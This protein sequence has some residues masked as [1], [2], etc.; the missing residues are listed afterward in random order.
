[1]ELTLLC[2]AELAPEL[3]VPDETNIN[4]S[5]FMT[6]PCEVTLK[7][8]LFSK[9][10]CKNACEHVWEAPPPLAPVSWSTYEPDTPSDEDVLSKCRVQHKG[11][12]IDIS[13]LAPL[14][15]VLPENNGDKYSWQIGFCRKVAFSSILPLE[16]CTGENGAGYV[17]QYSGVTCQAEFN[18]NL[19][20][21]H[22]DDGR[23]YGLDIVADGTPGRHHDKQV[24][25][26]VT[27]DATAKGA[28]IDY[29]W[30]RVESVV[31][32]KTR[33]Y[34]IHLKSHCACH[35]ACSHK[36]LSAW[37]EESQAFQTNEAVELGLFKDCSVKGLDLSGLNDDV[38][39]YPQQWIGHE[40]AQANHEQYYW[41]IGFCHQVVTPP[42]LGFD[43]CTFRGGWGYL[44]QFSRGRCQ[45]NFKHDPVIAALPKSAGDGVSFTYHDDHDQSQRREA[46][47]AVRCDPDQHVL[48]WDAEAMPTMEV[49]VEDLPG[50]GL[51]YTMAFKHRCVCSTLQ[52]PCE[53]AIVKTVGFDLPKPSVARDLAQCSMSGRNLAGL[54]VF[55]NVLVEHDQNG[56]QTG[57][58]ALWVIGFCNSVTE[59]DTHCGGAGFAQ[60]FSQ[61]Q[62]VNNF[63]ASEG[64]TV[65]EQDG[66]VVR[67]VTYD[68]QTNADTSHKLHVSI[69]CRED[70]KPFKVQPKGDFKYTAVQSEG[71]LS[72]YY[73][74]FYSKC[75]CKDGCSDVSHHVPPTAHSP[76]RP[77]SPPPAP[78]P[79]RPSGQPVSSLG[80]VDQI[81]GPDVTPGNPE[82][83][84]A[85]DI[86]LSGILYPWSQDLQGVPSA[87]QFSTWNIGFC[88]QVDHS[89]TRFNTPCTGQPGYV[90]YWQ[91][92]KCMLSTDSN[93]QLDRCNS[94]QF[95]GK[96]YPQG[97]RLTST[98]M[99]G[100]TTTTARIIVLCDPSVKSANPA[101]YSDVVQSDNTFT[102]VF[103]SSCACSGRDAEACPTHRGPPVAVLPPPSPVDDNDASTAITPYG[104]CYASNDQ[105][106]DISSLTYRVYTHV[107]A[108]WS[109]ADYS[110]GMGWCYPRNFADV[111]FNPCTRYG[112]GFFEIWGSDVD[113][114]SAQ[115]C[116]AHFDKIEAI[117]QQTNPAI[118]RGNGL[119]IKLSSTSSLS[120]A[121]INLVCDQKADGTEPCCD[122]DKHKV[123]RKSLGGV[124]NYQIT[125]ESKCACPGGCPKVDVADGADPADEVV[126]PYY[127]YMYQDCRLKTPEGNIDLSS[128]DPWPI[129][130]PDRHTF[131]QGGDEVPYQWTVGLC[132]RVAQ[133]PL[134]TKS[135]DVCAQSKGAGWL[136]QY[137]EDPPKCYADFNDDFWSMRP[138]VQNSKVLGVNVTVKTSAGQTGAGSKHHT[139]YAEILMMCNMDVAGEPVAKMDDV[140]VD[141][142][143]GPTGAI[144]YIYKMTFEHKCACPGANCYHHA[145]PHLRTESQAVEHITECGLEKHN[146]YLGTLPTPYEFKQTQNY[147][148]EG[149]I[150]SGLSMFGW[151]VG[152]CSHVVKTHEGIDPC[153]IQAEKD[154]RQPGYIQQYSTNMQGEDVTGCAV[155]FNEV[156]A[157]A[158]YDEAT[159]TVNVW[160]MFR[161]SH[162]P[163]HHHKI[164]NMKLICAPSMEPGHVAEES[165]PISV[166]PTPLKLLPPDLKVCACVRHCCFLWTASF[167]CLLQ[168]SFLSKFP[169]NGRDIPD[170]MDILEYQMNFQYGIVYLLFSPVSCGLIHP[171]S[172]P[173]RLQ[174][175]VCLQ[176]WL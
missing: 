78:R 109:A 87:R 160:Y 63:H 99:V 120:A 72:A 42:A 144:E 90:Q 56:A 64:F 93:L 164:V 166:L 130:M 95:K 24:K 172:M 23:D 176:G 67:F 153:I 100:G 82:E 10:A 20:V 146:V 9:C 38:K 27:C 122:D 60:R 66:G 2:S 174:F 89:Q 77:S 81:C 39:L 143:L 58:E 111:G 69:Y 139:K 101:Q 19:K 92:E 52:T 105:T 32:G 5:Q 131:E 28:E 48:K 46:V 80:E 170:D 71:S 65:D 47:I 151:A 16:P 41:S 102:I 126:F 73:I 96:S 118:G 75:A 163:P 113:G 54:D 133:D 34:T 114:R 154:Q 98:S 107:P 51:K 142:F 76:P 15:V 124:L 149:H 59:K 145:A 74:D 138:L 141:Q 167:F 21:T 29:L 18:S 171:L 108:S 155:D 49:K 61:G 8:S 161:N 88:S 168:R 152:W 121:T 22:F 157:P 123:I 97:V 26:R 156:L 6:N 53:H 36:S 33:Y 94:A 106:R 14:D 162:V 117:L 79:P 12:W 136:H 43:P 116:E 175:Q 135:G 44:Q 104:A 110:L 103:G 129:V 147:T 55:E 13:S 30:D 137:R 7:M 83:C 125:L 150:N 11:H 1:M 3:L 17:N 37:Q 40:D 127:S 169:D 86:D 57:K 4:L 165:S 132:R 50:N 84:T 134:N 148:Q 91:D 68:E 173:S 70:M 115:G 158:T 62:C 128:I 25:V 31:E 45:A 159:Q 35:D 119:V 85:D 140:V 112:P